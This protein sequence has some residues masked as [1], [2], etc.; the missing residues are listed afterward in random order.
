MNKKG[1]GEQQL[2]YDFQ[3]KWILLGNFAEYY[4]N[5][6]KLPHPEILTKLSAAHYE[7]S[8]SEAR[9]Y[10]TK[11]AIDT[12]EKFPANGKRD[13]IINEKNQRM[14][15][16][17]MEISKRNTLHLYAER[18]TEKKS[19]ETIHTVSSL[20]QPSEKQEDTYV[21]FSGFMHWTLF[22]KE[23]EVFSYY[24]GEYQFNVSKERYAYL[25][26]INK[27]KGVDIEM[28]RKLTEILCKQKHGAAAVVF[29]KKIDAEAEANRLCNMK[30]GT[31]ICSNICYNQTTGWNKEQ[32]L[33]VTGIDGALFIDHEGK[34][35]AIGVIV[36]GEMKIKGDVGRGARY[37]SIANYM[38]L[39]PGCVGIVV[40]E[41]GMVNVIQK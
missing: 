7:G 40:S 28:I 37:N 30:R 41:D 29:N 3:K 33:S 26:V 22:E 12:I 38:K 27:L 18:S 8:E 21:E 6:N 31:K 4:M 13:R 15:R 11:N 39:K 34:C 10:F 5:K 1:L 16:K 32:I 9:I 14:I 2:F 35:L 17:L 23:R 19:Q 20:V 24:N 25:E 36:D